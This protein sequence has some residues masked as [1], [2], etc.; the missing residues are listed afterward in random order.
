ML[1]NI[2]AKIKENFRFCSHFRWREIKRKF[3]NPNPDIMGFRKLFR[4][5][6]FIV[7]F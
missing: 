2:F 6:V 5:A 3:G 4:K 1:T 7:I